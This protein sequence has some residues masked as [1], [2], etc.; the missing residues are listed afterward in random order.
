MPFDHWKNGSKNKGKIKILRIQKIL[1]QRPC[2]QKAKHPNKTMKEDYRGV[3]AEKPE[4]RLLT[5]Y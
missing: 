5:E 1:F 3:N 2:K 4:Q